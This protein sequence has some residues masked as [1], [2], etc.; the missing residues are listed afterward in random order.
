MIRIDKEKKRQPNDLVGFKVVSHLA[1]HDDSAV[2]W[3]HQTFNKLIVF[4]LSCTD[5]GTHNIV[6]L[7]HGPVLQTH[8]FLRWNYAN[9]CCN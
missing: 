7:F 6:K 1:S 8:V 5:E 9:L 2:M 4:V 3:I